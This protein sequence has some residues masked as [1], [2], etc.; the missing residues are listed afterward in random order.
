[1]SERGSDPTEAPPAGSAPIELDPEP[2]SLTGEPDEPAGPPAP[3]SRTKKIVL[4]S[5]LA[6]GLAGVAA[7]GVAGWRIASQ[8]DA[9]VSA[10]DQVAGLRRDDS[11][12][13]KST[14]DYLQTALSAEVDL[15]HA[16]GA[17]YLGGDGR[18]VLFT[19]GNSLIWSPDSDLDSAFS[20]VSDEQG[21]VVGVH[22]VPAGTFGGTMKCGTTVTDDGDMAVCGWADHGSLALAMFP[23]RSPGDAAKLLLDIRAQAQTRN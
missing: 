16:V 20:L 11:Q 5:L 12:E 10:P 3:P 15:D 8:K 7:V 21:A 1:M 9:T 14:A 22:D 23:K 19:G 17:V 6:V 4:I 13:G 18:N 2:F